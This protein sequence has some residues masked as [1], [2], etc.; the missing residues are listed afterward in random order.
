MRSVV[1]LFVFSLSACGT[2]DPPKS[3]TAPTTSSKPPPGPSASASAESPP[4]HGGTKQRGLEV[5]NQLTGGELERAEHACAS[6]P[7]AEREACV[8]A[9]MAEYDAALDAKVARN[10]RSMELLRLAGEAECTKATPS[11]KKDCVLGAMNQKIVELSRDC[12][13]EPEAKHDCIVRKLLERYGP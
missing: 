9:R 12:P 13:E 8:D 3:A 10:M 1:L 4:P 2:H 6:E 11:E 5:A 7:E